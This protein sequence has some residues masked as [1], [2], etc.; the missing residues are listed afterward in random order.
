MFTGEMF[1]MDE[2]D[3][4]LAEASIAPDLSKLKPK[5]LK[6]VEETLK[7][8]TLIPPDSGAFMQQGSRSGV[9]SEHLGHM[10]SEMQ[11][12]PRSYPDAKW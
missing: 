12:L 7:E 5:W 9:H 11:I 2:T 1:E 3:R 6:L 4:V 10:L 8:A